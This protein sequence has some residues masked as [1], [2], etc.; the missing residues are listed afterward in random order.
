MAGAQ[1]PE[2]A[3]PA[4]GLRRTGLAAAEFRACGLTTGQR[5]RRVRRLNSGR[6][7]GR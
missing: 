1:E 3:V 6:G 7:P 2:L 5:V 4:I